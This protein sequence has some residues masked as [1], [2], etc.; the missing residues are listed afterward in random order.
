MNNAVRVSPAPLRQMKQPS[1][2]LLTFIGI[3][4]IVCSLV[5]PLLSDFWD[6]YILSYAVIFLAMGLGYFLQAAFCAAVG[7]RRVDGT[8]TYESNEK[9]YSFPRAVPIIVVAIIL[10]FFVSSLVDKFLYERAN[11]PG[12]SYDPNSVIPFLVAAVFVLVVAVGSFVWFFP[13]NRIMTGS[14]FLVGVIIFGILFVLYLSG[15]SS[16]TVI[17]GINFI[18]YCFCALICTN[19]Y[20]I[21]KTYRGTVVSFMTKKTRMYNVALTMLLSLAFLLLLFIFY[22]IVNG[23]RVIFLFLLAA[24][25]SATYND[26]AG[27]TE[28]KEEVAFDNLS[29]YLFAT[30]DVKSAPEYWYFIIFVVF[31]LVFLIFMLT[32]RAPEMRRFLSWLK[33]SILAFIDMIFRPIA[34]YLA[35]SE[36]GFSNF[37]D[38]EERMQRDEVRARVRTEKESEMTYKDFY[39]RLRSIRTPED[40]YRYAYHTLVLRLRKIQGL[41]KKSDTPR[42]I[43]DKLRSSGR[44]AG[45]ETVSRISSE[46][47]RIEFADEK[48]GESTDAV[49]SSLCDVI[50]ENMQE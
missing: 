16:Y 24:F 5:A 15:G 17:I 41:I 26:D 34:D 43:S 12:M 29:E 42:Q 7:F 38:E 11:Q 18:V 22:L 25:F 9:F 8:R 14:A 33:N 39:S 47:E 32:K 48:A 50:K 36:R 21:G 1:F 20:A 31:S 2:R 28:E 37:V 40:R 45:A 49:L 30:T 44:V 19:Q 6:A 10:S 13:Y 46:F 4:T 23:F 3:F 27:Y 35:P